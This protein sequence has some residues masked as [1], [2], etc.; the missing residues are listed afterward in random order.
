MI[1]QELTQSICANSKDMLGELI[2]EDRSYVKQS[3]HS[4]VCL[5]SYSISSAILQSYLMLSCISTI[6][7]DN[8]ISFHTVLLSPEATGAM[9]LFLKHNAYS[10]ISATEIIIPIN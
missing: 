7:D 6:G 10:D 8:F 5:K 9:F 3:P 4:P 1:V 2:G